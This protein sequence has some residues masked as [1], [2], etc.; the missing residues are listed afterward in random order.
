DKDDD[1]YEC[2]SVQTSHTQDVK[3]IKWHPE[4]EILASASYDNTCK[5]F[6]EE[7][8]D[9]SCFCTL[10]GHQSTVWSIDFDKTGQRLVSC[11]DDRTIK[12][13][14][15]YQAGNPEGIPTSGGTSI[16]KC[17]CTIQGYHD[18]PIYDVS[19]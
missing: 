14:Q 1:D 9:W 16:W 3:K 12:I 7:G 2:A 19:W 13:W 5:L 4:K 11:S 10:E 8:D 6:H 18:R 15:E 17:T